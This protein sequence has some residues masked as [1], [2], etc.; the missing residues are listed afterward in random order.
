M[1]DK[2]DIL[3]MTIEIDQNK[4]QLK[5]K[6]SGHHNLT[7]DEIKDTIHDSIDLQFEEFEG[8]LKESGKEFDNGIIILPLIKINFKI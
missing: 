3:V 5:I 7:I 6:E 2:L 8:K 4:A 1:K